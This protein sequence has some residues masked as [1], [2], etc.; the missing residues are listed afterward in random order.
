MHSITTEKSVKMPILTD[1]YQSSDAAFFC[2]C[3][4]VNFDGAVCMPDPGA[5]ESPAIA[6]IEKYQYANQRPMWAPAI[7]DPRDGSVIEADNRHWSATPCQA[8]TIASR[9]SA[10]RALP[11]RQELFTGETPLNWPTLIAKVSREQFERGIDLYIEHNGDTSA[12]DAMDAALPCVAAGWRHMADRDLAEFAESS[13]QLATG[14][15]ME[16]EVC[17]E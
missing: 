10:R 5:V 8:L 9:I 12:L 16:R 1:F 11:I 7:V 6:I 4:Q 3:G 2:M 15:G 17:Y 13:W 14:V